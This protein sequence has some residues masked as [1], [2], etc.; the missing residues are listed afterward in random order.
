VSDTGAAIPHDKLDEI[1]LPFTRVESNNS[2]AH[3]SGFG[4]YVVKGLTEL[5]GGSISVDSTVGK[6]TRVYI[7]LPA[8]PASVVT[9]TSHPKRIAVIEDDP[10]MHE[11]ANDMLRRLGH[12]VVDKGYNWVLTDMEMGETSG[13]DILARENGIPVVLMTGSTLINREKA[14]QL[15]F[16]GFISKPFTLRDLENIFGNA[17]I[18]EEDSFFTTDD[19]IISLF[20][21]STVENKEYLKQA[22]EADNFAKAQAIC[23][24]M[25]PM[26]AQLGYPTTEVARM[27]A[28]RGKMYEGWQSDVV[29]IIEIKV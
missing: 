17:M 13:L 5:M 2:L 20:R 27:D 24:K 7:D 23:H 9:T 14:L 3:G 25:L 29:A 12:E 26:M 11:L 22:L 16:A 19:E 4:M 28:A 15:G 10:L 8:Q 21:N 18:E 1:F 6:G